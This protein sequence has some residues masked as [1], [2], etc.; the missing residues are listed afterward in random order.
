MVTTTF[1]TRVTAHTVC[2]QSSVTD[3]QSGPAAAVTV[4][5]VR[6]STTDLESWDGET[7][8]F[9][10]L[11]RESRHE[12]S[13]SKISRIKEGIVNSSEGLGKLQ[14]SLEEI[15]SPWGNFIHDITPKQTQAERKYE[16]EEIYH[17]IVIKLPMISNHVIADWGAQRAQKYVIGPHVLTWHVGT[18]DIYFIYPPLSLLVSDTR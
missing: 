6:L 15:N 12:A 5:A 18:L 7:S 2:V 3:G 16:D 4:T 14:K 8:G 1:S 10:P 11:K 13:C 9:S 17:I